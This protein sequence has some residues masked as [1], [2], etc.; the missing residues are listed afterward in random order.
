[1]PTA[2]RL[3]PSDVNEATSRPLVLL[4]DDDLEVLAAL[5]RELRDE[6]YDLATAG[7]AAQALACLRGRPAH[8]VV[9]DERMPGANGSELLAELRDRWPWIG[10]VILTGYPGADVTIRGL[11]VGVDFVLQKPWEPETLKRTLRRLLLEVERSRARTAEE[12]SGEPGLGVGG[13]GD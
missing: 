12:T 6:P 1:M 13:E 4:V 8:V 2:I 10:R 11:E 7:S 3:K 9:A 5:R